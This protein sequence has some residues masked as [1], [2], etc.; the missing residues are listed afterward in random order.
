[1]N[2]ALIK[3]VI[4]EKSMYLASTGVYTFMIQPSAT[5]HQVK[6]A[7]ETLFGVNVLDVKTTTIHTPTATT[8]RR[9][10]KVARSNRKFARVSLKKGQS[11]SLFDLKEN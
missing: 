11:I 2:N 10:I 7:V 6:T 8:G 4:T 3:P 9:R 1:M 5:K